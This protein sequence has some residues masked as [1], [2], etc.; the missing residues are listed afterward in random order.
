MTTCLEK[1]CSFG[2]PRVPFVNCCQF[3]YI[4]ISLLVLRSG[5]GIWL[6]HCLYFYLNDWDTYA[7]WDHAQP[8]LDS[9]YANLTIELSHYKTN[10]MTCASSDDSHE[11]GRPTSLIRVFAV[12]MKKKL[13]S[14]ATYWA[15]SKDSKQT[16]RTPRL[17]WVFAGR[18]G[19]VFDFVMRRLSYLYKNNIGTQCEALVWCIPV[20]VFYRSKAVLRRL[21]WCFS[22]LFYIVRLLVTDHRIFSRIW[23]F[24]Y[25]VFILIL[26]CRALWFNRPVGTIFVWSGL[27]YERRDREVLL[28]VGVRGAFSP[29]NKNLNLDALWCNLELFLNKF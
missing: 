26:F 6:Y 7:F 13:G 10:K 20:F 22:T 4:V 15:H 2:L 21:F 9:L 23:W 18:T 27:E 3:M 5:Y 17:I 12:H 11:P 1:S 19:N 25:Y 8:K 24:G 14:L 28:G 29:E 16:E